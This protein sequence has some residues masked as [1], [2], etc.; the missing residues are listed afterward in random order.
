MFWSSA[1]RTGIGWYGG[2]WRKG[3]GLF[4][5]EFELGELV[6]DLLEGPLAE[7]ADFEQALLGLFD[8]LAECI[9]I[10]LLEALSGT[11]GEAEWVDGTTKQRLPKYVGC[12]GV[13]GDDLFGEFRFEKHACHD[14]IPDP[15]LEE[16][17]SC[18]ACMFL[19]GI[20]APLHHRFFGHHCCEFGR[21]VQSFHELGLWL[22]EV[23]PRLIAMSG[24]EPGY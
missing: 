1:W 18:L 20:G 5:L 13:S 9:D 19:N 2:L 11:G 7:I 14:Q 22:H 23:R 8:E 15:L 6:D 24:S 3:R 10:L 4:E 12:L 17:I 21:D 16:L